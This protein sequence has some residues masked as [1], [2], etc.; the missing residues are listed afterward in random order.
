[1]VTLI[2]PHRNAKRLV[3]YDSSI[4]AWKIIRFA[5]GKER[6]FGTTKEPNSW[7]FHHAFVIM[8]VENAGTFQIEYF[9]VEFGHLNSVWLTNLGNELQQDDIYNWKIPP[10]ERRLGDL[11]S[12]QGAC[13]FMLNNCQHF[14]SRVM[15]FLEHEEDHPRFHWL[16][17]L[18]GLRPT[19][20]SCTWICCKDET[21]YDTLK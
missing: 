16:F 12:H 18:I 21:Q 1:M 17:D 4:M 20:T 11:P 13:N 6:I 14:A 15:F 2:R 3:S 8:E 19:A 7:F 10:R 9:R 5:S